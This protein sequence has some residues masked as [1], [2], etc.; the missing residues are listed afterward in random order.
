MGCGA[1]TERQR[2]R[3]PGTGYS[4]AWTGAGRA[5]AGHRSTSRGYFRRK[6]GNHPRRAREQKYIE[7]WRR[8][9]QGD[10]A[11]GLADA[12]SGL[13]LQTRPTTRSSLMGITPSSWR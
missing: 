1:A 5:G 4:D 11:L 12:R 13:T 7:T 8:R 9:S 3:P 2:A 10:L 6:G